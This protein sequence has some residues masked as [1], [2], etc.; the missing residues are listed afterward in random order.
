[1]YFLVYHVKPLPDL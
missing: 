1:M